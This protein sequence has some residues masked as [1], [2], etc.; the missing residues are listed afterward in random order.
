MLFSF[1]VYSKV[2]QLYTDM[3]LFFFKVFSHLGYYRVLSRVPCAIYST[4]FLVIYFKCSSVYMSIP[5][6]QS[7][8]R[9]DLRKTIQGRPLWKEIF[10][11]RYA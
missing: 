3:Y 4:S 7:I 1:Q 10:G 9:A 8:P 2:I 6:S 5:N 11:L